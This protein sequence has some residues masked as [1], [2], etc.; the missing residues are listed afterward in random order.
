MKPFVLGRK[1]Y[2]NY[3]SLQ[4]ASNAT[5]MYTLEESCKMSDSSPVVYNKDVLYSLI[6]VEPDYLQLI[7]SYWVNNE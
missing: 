6:K 3:D 4:G 5:Y 1:N 2:M 7:L